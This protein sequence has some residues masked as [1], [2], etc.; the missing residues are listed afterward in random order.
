MASA[1]RQLRLFSFRIKRFDSIVRR[2]L[3]AFKHIRKLNRTAINHE[4]MLKPDDL[5]TECRNNR[6]CKQSA[7]HCI[8]ESKED[9]VGLIVGLGSEHL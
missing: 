6:K 9:F 5:S 1:G 7:F 2:S 8:G 3:I 4:T